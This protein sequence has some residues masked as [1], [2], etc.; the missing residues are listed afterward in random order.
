MDIEPL[1]PP[2]ADLGTAILGSWWLRSRID[3]DAT[4]NRSICPVLGAEPLGF[5][6]FA[7]DRFAAQ[8]MR[9]GREGD[10]GT[11]DARGRVSAA[12]QMGNNTSAV[13]GY[14]AYFGTYRLDPVAGTVAVTLEA[15]LTP[16]NIGQTF[17]REIRADKDRLV[18]RLATQAADGTPITRTLT[19][20]R[21]R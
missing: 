11:M 6:T 14:D 20:D 21:I 7:R 8:F 2:A 16:A 17:L 13:G 1:T 12:P 9:R 3:L 18:I 19:F 5:L 10:R 4:G 15:A